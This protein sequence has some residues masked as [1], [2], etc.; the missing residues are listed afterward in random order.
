MFPN[1]VIY[2]AQERR[3]TR[4]EGQ[5]DVTFITPSL[6]PGIREYLSSCVDWV[7]RIY[8][9]DNKRKITFVY[10]ESLEAKDRASLFPK[11]LNLPPIV[12]GINPA[13]GA[14]RKR[15]VESIHD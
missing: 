3:K 1:D 11:V 2:L 12:N 9:E 5:G 6:T 15:I 14:I 10:Q 8:V 4:D 13:Y 7:G